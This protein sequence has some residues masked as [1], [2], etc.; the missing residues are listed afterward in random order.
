MTHPVHTAALQCFERGWSVIPLIGGDDPARGKTP[1]TAWSR[2]RER[3]PSAVELRQ[4]FESG[5]H[6][7]YGIVCGR[8]SQL[9]VLDFDDETVAAQFR[10]RFPDLA[11]TLTVRSGMRGTPHLYFHVDFPVVSRRFHGGDMKGE[12]GYVVGP[13]SVI[14]GRCWTA[15]HD[16]P[17]LAIMPELL[18]AVLDFLGATDD[19]DPSSGDKSLAHAHEINEAAVVQQYRREAARTGQRNNTLFRIACQLR[20]K[21]VSQDWTL[22][23]LAQA[24]AEQPARSGAACE[25]LDR[26]LG[27]AEC[28]IASAYRRPPRRERP[29]PPDADDANQPLDNSIREAL[30]QRPDGAAFLRVYEGLRMLGVKADSTFTRQ[31]ALEL[32]KGIV[33]DYS[34]RKALHLSIDGSAAAFSA[35]PSGSQP[36]QGPEN[37][38]KR[39]FV[40]QQEPT[41]SHN[42]AHRPA[43]RYRM[44]SVEELRTWL[45]VQPTAGDPVELDELRSPKSY[46]QALEREFI[47]RRPGQYPQAW[48][49]HRLGVSTRSIY[50]YHRAEG[51]VAEPCFITTPLNWSNY[52]RM[53]P[54]PGMAKRIGLNTRGRFIEDETGKRYPALIGVAQQ[55][56]GR[57]NHIVSCERTFG[58]YRWQYRVA[59]QNYAI[60]GTRALDMMQRPRAAAGEDVA[61]KT[62]ELTEVLL[63]RMSGLIRSAMAT[64]AIS[65][66][67]A[68]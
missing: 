5:K 20:D 47:R 25:T 56:M 66:P 64:R 26:R 54:P 28:T 15:V 59:G 44:P 12:G 1:A 13:E 46:R 40:P 48:L 37:K 16:A 57:G 6:S 55:L 53:L 19:L 3:M 14:G 30:L 31:E 65:A 18:A 68:K 32:L 67:L 24:H 63:T 10:R 50:N 61:A 21:G 2:Y 36:I 42:P 38:A 58:H 22:R 34:L 17:V 27:E 39:C 35:H 43:V 8:L 51:V 33:G 62:D 52:E 4:W 29:K 7:A 23:C 9:V 60:N 45:G 11:A 41:R 49:A